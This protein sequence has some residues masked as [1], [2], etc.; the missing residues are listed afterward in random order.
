MKQL[1]CLPCRL[2]HWSPGWLENPTTSGTS[3]FRS[4]VQCRAANVMNAARSDGSEPGGA[5][6]RKCTV[7]EETKPP[8]DAVAWR[9]RILGV[10]KGWCS[11]SRRRAIMRPLF[12]LKPFL[13][14]KRLFVCLGGVAGLYNKTWVF[15][16][17][18]LYIVINPLFFFDFFY[19][20]VSFTLLVFI[21]S[22]Y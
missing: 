13:L 6:C 7:A 8:V 5:M 2:F 3:N 17:I 22:F 10:E 15:L 9:I 16:L 21:H 4:A 19:H 1:L 14:L 11:W 18:D 12:Y 20:P